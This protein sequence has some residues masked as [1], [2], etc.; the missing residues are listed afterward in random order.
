MAQHNYPSDP[1]RRRIYEWIERKIIGHCRFAL[2]T[3][4]GADFLD[5]GRAVVL[6]DLGLDLFHHVRTADVDALALRGGGGIAHE[7][8]L[9]ANPGMRT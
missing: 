6:L 7:A 8:E 3:A 5:D 1:K 9:H 4:P 2:L